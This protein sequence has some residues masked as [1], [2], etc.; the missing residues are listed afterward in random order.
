MPGNAGKPAGTRHRATEA[1]LA[2]MGESAKQITAAVVQ[3]ALS[4][5]MIAARLVIDRLCPPAR[6]RPVRLVLPD[7]ATAAGCA[8][9]Q[10]AI[11]QSVAAGQ[12]TPNEAATLSGVIEGLRR[13]L[14]TESLEVRIRALEAKK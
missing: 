4:G 14:E 13:S 11:L 2:L 1:V 12:I 5:D 7:T 3:A 9:A 8:E 10:A 6:E